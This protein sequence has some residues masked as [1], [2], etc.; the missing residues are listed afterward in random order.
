[1]ITARFF[2]SPDVFSLGR[3]SFSPLPARPGSGADEL[4]A[5]LSPQARDGLRRQSLGAGWE[6]LLNPMID[7]EFSIDNV[8]LQS[9]A[10]GGATDHYGPDLDPQLAYR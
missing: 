4:P 6:G 3:G 1:M 5:I 7:P 9:G 10:N 8:P 2:P